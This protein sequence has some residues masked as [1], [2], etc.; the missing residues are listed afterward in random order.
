MTRM[1]KQYKLICKKTRRRSRRTWF[2]VIREAMEKRGIDKEWSLDRARW[3]VALE[4][5]K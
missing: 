5:G 2:D 3:K 4:N 1:A